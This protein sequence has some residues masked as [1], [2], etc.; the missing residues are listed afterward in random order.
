MWYRLVRTRGFWVLGTEEL[1]MDG[2]FS[3]LKLAAVCI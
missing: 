3:S 1:V 2:F